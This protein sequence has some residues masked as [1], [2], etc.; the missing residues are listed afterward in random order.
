MAVGT[1]TPM[2]SG[3]RVATASRTPVVADV[4]IEL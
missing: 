1:F 3:L 2:N 4:K